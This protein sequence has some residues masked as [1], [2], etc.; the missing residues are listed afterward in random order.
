M[1]KKTSVSK[2]ICLNAETLKLAE[3]LMQVTGERL[4]WVIREGIREL[5]RIRVVGKEKVV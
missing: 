4:S 1:R 3:E 2:T 5:H